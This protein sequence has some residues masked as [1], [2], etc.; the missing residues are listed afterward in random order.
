MKTR[1]RKITY[2]ALMTALI[3]VCSQLSLPLPSGVP[4]TL[5][6]FA[7]A[8]GGYVLG[9]PLGVAAVAAYLA[10]GAFG[11]PVFSSFRGGIG[12]FTGPTGG[13]LAGFL[14]LS[15]F[16][17]LWSMKKNMLVNCLTGA[18]GLL[19]CHLLGVLWFSSVSGNAFPRSFLLVSA[20]YLI[21]DVVSVIAARYVAG[22]VLKRTGTVRR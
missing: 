21:K 20:P 18:F 12:M 1:S 3:A 5:Q 6:T 10:L 19:I 16:C 2:T 7:V 9:L 4:L 22:A 17:G 8:L 11:L 15:F 14:F 13:F